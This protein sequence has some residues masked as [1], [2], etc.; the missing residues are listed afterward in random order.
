MQVVYEPE[1]MHTLDHYSQQRKLEHD[2]VTRE[3]WQ[4]SRAEPKGLKLFEAIPEIS[5]I[6]IRGSLKY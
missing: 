3:R 2:G 4:L 5:E 6:F 1:T